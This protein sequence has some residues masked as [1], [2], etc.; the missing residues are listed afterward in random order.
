MIRLEKMEDKGRKR[1]MFRV[2]FPGQRR[3]FECKSEPETKQRKIEAQAEI[4]EA[5]PQDDTAS[6]LAEIESQY[7]NFYNV[8]SDQLG[9]VGRR[10]DEIESRVQTISYCE[11]DDETTQEIP[12]DEETPGK[13]NRRWIIETCKGSDEPEPTSESNKPPTGEFDKLFSTHEKLMKAFKGDLPVKKRIVV[14]QPH[15]YDQ[16]KSRL[17]EQDRLIDAILAKQ[18]ETE[19]QLKALPD[20]LKPI[21]DL[22]QLL[23]DRSGKQ[24]EEFESVLVR[25]KNI[26][27]L[28]HNRAVSQKEDMSSVL[29]RIEKLEKGRHD[30]EICRIASEYVNLWWETTRKSISDD[31]SNK[32]S[33]ERLKQSFQECIKQW[34]NDTYRSFYNEMT[35]KV[36]DERKH[37]EEV[38]KK[39]YE[40]IK[41]ENAKSLQRA[42]YMDQFMLLYFCQY[43][44]SFPNA[45][46]VQWASI[47][48][49]AV[50]SMVP[51]G[52][53]NALKVGGPDSTGKYPAHL[54]HTNLIVDPKEMTEIQ[55]NDSTKLAQVKI[56][57][58]SRAGKEAVNKVLEPNNNNSSKALPPIKSIVQTALPPLKNTTQ[59]TTTAA[60]KIT[61]PP[62]RTVDTTQDA[63]QKLA[64]SR[65]SDTQK[66]IPTPPQKPLVL[67]T[68]K[69]EKPPENKLSAP[70]SERHEIDDFIEV[71]DLNSDSD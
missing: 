10:M 36:E 63:L 68:P 23:K 22:G 7:A 64:K 12:D 34:W 15:D 17:D 47:L 56:D 35:K 3:K 33:N 2:S 42:C 20:Q 32:T 50:K 61:L 6:R 57:L 21:I 19:N 53:S 54:I 65:L 31:I 58:L 69:I 51:T 66:I 25:L 26:E 55:K 13:E 49:E 14:D 29:D 60:I 8:L 1:G 24:K 41:Q 5:K 67:Q 37:T 18:L 30:L 27:D 9:Q 46:P 40:I 71:L 39:I 59:P 28:Y 38:K 44:S 52:Y 43:N 70:D 48:Y 11:D 16:L 45:P 4:Q 62:I